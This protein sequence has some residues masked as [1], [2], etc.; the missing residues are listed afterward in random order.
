MLLLIGVASALAADP[1]AGT[2][3]QNKSMGGG[4]LSIPSET[5]VFK[6]IEI[7]DANIAKITD[8]ESAGEETFSLDGTLVRIKKGRNAGEDD[9]LKRL[10]AKVWAFQRK[11]HGRTYP[12]RKDQMAYDEEGYYTISVDEKIMIWAVLR[13][14]SDGR[15]IYY[16]RVFERQ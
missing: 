5:P 4:A 1:F 8:T 16:N 6:T 13:T 9:S 14:Y 15:T 7:V 3:K 11:T 12:D 10:H 2:W